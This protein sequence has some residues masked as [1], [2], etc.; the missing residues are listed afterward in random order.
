MKLEKY[1]EYKAS[2]VFY[3]GDIPNNWIVTRNKYIAEIKGRI[4]FKGYTKEDF[5]SEGNGALVLGATEM[6]SIGKIILNNPQYINWFKYY[7][8]PEI[9]VRNKS[10][11]NR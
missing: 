2:G 3:I 7:E 5:V 9:M 4:G 6:T 8:S 1:K 10:G 11:T